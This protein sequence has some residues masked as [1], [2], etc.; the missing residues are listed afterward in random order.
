MR[1]IQLSLF[2]IVF[3]ALAHLAAADEMR[4][5]LFGE[6][7]SALRKANELSANVL[8][9][10]SY[11]K[12][13]DYYRR[14]DERF[15]KGKS[16]DRIKQDLAQATQ[17][18]KQAI[19]GVE[20]AEVTFTTMIRARKDALTAK[21]DQYAPELWQEAAED[22]AAAAKKL[23]GGNVKSA[24]KLAAKAE[25]AL[26][27]AELAAIKAN[28]LNETRNIIARAKND[29][30][31]K[32]A[33]KTLAKAESLL[34]QAEQ[35]LS[36]NR[37]DIDQPRSLA[38]EA[39][40]EANHAIQIASKVMP[41]MRGDREP[42]DVI[43]EMEE[44]I[45]RVASALDLVAELDG[46]SEDPMKGIMSRISELQM[47][48]YELGEAEQRLQQLDTEIGYLE[49]R[50]GMQ[51]ERLARQERRRALF[52]KADSLF[53]DEEAVVLT[54]GN[55]I[56]VRMVGL[57]FAPG[58][59]TIESQYFGILAKVQ[60]A[61][62]LFPQAPVIVEGHT[63]SFG[64]DEINLELSRQRAEAV[65]AYLLANMPERTNMSISADGFGETRPIGNNETVDGRKR[66]R[67]IDLVIKTE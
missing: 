49:E 19:K 18:Y 62:D 30:V 63:D 28:Y 33:P 46:Q 36:E 57:N 2:T 54:K 35:A 15:E 50:M 40:Y 53:E 10:V 58:K 66:N 11:G 9:P 34:T 27:A 39:N 41:L 14:A 22:F 61:M 67:R 1:I 20:L 31:Y 43:L 7:D 44:P 16:I 60:K 65:R 32:Y 38:R 37:Y 29:K 56:L 6:A 51:N 48:S 3:T 52:E 8:T 25:S 12:A 17:L 59:S 5:S 24:S 4:E 23:E 42:E 26:R 13:S 21:A 55:D 45:V 64:G 47:R